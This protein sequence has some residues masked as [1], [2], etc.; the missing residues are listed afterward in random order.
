MSILLHFRWFSKTGG[1]SAKSIL[2]FDPFPI[3]KKTLKQFDKAKNYSTLK[4]VRKRDVKFMSKSIKPQNE[5]GMKLP[6][7]SFKAS[8]D[9]EAENYW[10]LRLKPKKNIPNARQ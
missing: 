1:F 6:T 7:V 2:W 10:Q 4:K 3:F 9:S 8:S 5:L